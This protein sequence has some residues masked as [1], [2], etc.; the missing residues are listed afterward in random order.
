MS[1]VRMLAHSDITTAPEAVV[2]IINQYEIVR[3]NLQTHTDG[4]FP[5]ASYLLERLKSGP[6]LYGMYALEAL[7]ANGTLS[8]GAKLLISVVDA[9]SQRLYVQ[10][11]GGVNTLAEALWYVQAYR[12]TG[13]VA[14][15]VSKLS[16]Y[17]ISDQDDK[18]WIRHT[19]PSIR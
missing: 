13:D 19:F 12:C 17:T 3:P 7:K 14:T 9:S 2:D 5:T 4:S 10:A 6:K 15:F 18:F 1:M 16:V 8:D 11:W